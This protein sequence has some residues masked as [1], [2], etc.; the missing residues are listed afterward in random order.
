LKAFGYF[1]D[2]RVARLVAKCS[3]G[4][5]SL[6]SERENMGL[7]GV[8]STQL[9]HHQF[10]ENFCVPDTRRREHATVR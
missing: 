4:K 9:I 2:K 1:D 8:L 3:Q 10:I 6:L 5:G 7:V